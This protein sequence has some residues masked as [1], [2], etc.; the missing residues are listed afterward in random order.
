MVFSEYPY[1]RPDMGAIRREAKAAIARMKK[2]ESYDAFKGAIREVLVVYKSLLTLQ[3]IASIRHTVNTKDAFYEQED[4]FFNSAVPKIMPVFLQYYKAMLKSPYLAQY[5]AEY[6][7]RIQSEA[8]L[9][10]K[11]F[12]NKLILP[13][14]KEN[15]LTSEYQKLL[16]SC[17]V[18][19]LGEKR[20]LPGITKLMQSPDRDV[21]RQAYRAYVG[22]F[23]ENEAKF[24]ELF[25]KLV[26]IRTKMG[27]MMGF[28]NFIPLAYLNMGRVDYG[29]KEVEQFR[30]QVERDLVPVT[31]RLRKAQAERIGV[32]KLHFYDEAFLYPDGNATPKGDRAFMVGQAQEMYQALSKETGEFFS[33][34][35]EHELMDLETKPGKAAGG[36]CTFLPDYGAP[37][38]FSN[39]NGTSGDVDV[40]TH[41]AGHA[42]E[43]YLASKTQELPEY[44]QSTSE[45]MEIHSMSM[46]FFTYPWMDKFFGDEVGK[47]KKLHTTGGLTFVPYGVCVDEFQHR[48]YEKPD[49]TPKERRA[50]WRALEKKYLPDRDYDGDE[51]MESGAFFFKQLHIFMYPF[52]YID[53]TLASMGAFEF[54]GKMG[55]DRPRAW[56]DYVT[57]CGLGGSKPYLELLRAANL[58]NPFEEG[59]VQK[60]IAP[61]VRFAEQ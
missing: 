58:S 4:K 28:D 48:V 56:N 1:K 3:N 45:I 29:P 22:F 9:Q 61:L 49:M 50:V 51:F 19:L 37:F 38:I 20:N 12:S 53:Y 36:Y 18:E 6:G 25:D 14:I 21:R 60:A 15:K 31:S 54:Y 43:M 7:E 13:M 47:Y 46:E 40:L 59:S 32:D 17:E 26:K 41:E 11:R 8:E 23:R 34:L 5:V 39:F 44:W 57:L 30:R 27:R 24:D 35:C 42:F 2:A 55:E 33:F 10:V 52:Y 16:A